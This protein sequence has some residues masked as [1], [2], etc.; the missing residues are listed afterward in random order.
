MPGPMKRPIPTSKPD[1]HPPADPLNIPLGI[2]AIDAVTMM[3]GTL[4]MRAVNL[5]NS[6]RYSIQPRG[7]GYD[8]PEAV[9]FDYHFIFVV[10]PGVSAC[11]PAQSPRTTLRLGEK[12]ENK[13]SKFA[14]IITEIV[15][16]MNGCQH[17]V[18]LGEKT[19]V[20]GENNDSSAANLWVKIGDGIAPKITVPK[21]EVDRNPPGGPMIRIRRSVAARS[22]SPFSR[23]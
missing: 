3:T 10:G 1:P 7:L 18:V 9:W 2:E 21:A 6:V 12:V 22:T 19:K 4:T 23:R 14:G 11:L 5:D 8:V 20:P 16:F 13:I 15:D 17:L